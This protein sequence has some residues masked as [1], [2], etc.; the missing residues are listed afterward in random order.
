MNDLIKVVE[1]FRLSNRPHFDGDKFSATIKFSDDVKSLLRLLLDERFQAGR[2][3]DLEIDGCAIYEAKDIPDN[4]NIVAY[5]FKVTQRSANR[6]YKN[7]SELVKIHTLKKGVMPEF[8]YVIEDDY[9]SGEN[10]KPTYIKKLEDICNLIESLSKLAHFHDTKND[11]KVTFYRLVFILHS[12][13]KSTSV[14][15]ETKITE[16]VLNDNEINLNLINS[17]VQVESNADIH[18]VEKI[19]TFRNTIIE[20]VSRNGSSFD[21]LIENWNSICELYS[22]NLAAYMSAFSFRKARKEVVDAE[23]EYSE[24]FSKII[25]EISNKALAIPISLA[26]SIAI[27]NLTSK[28]DWIVTFLGI[29]ITAIISSAMIVSQKKQLDRITHSK[30]IL[31]TQIKTRIKD[32]TS[33]LKASFQETIHK[34]DDNEDFCRKVLDIL[35]SLA[36][37]PTFI[38]IIGIFIKLMPNIN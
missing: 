27:F 26:G 15:I 18:Y 14:V 20:Y 2:L 10:N 31:F 21:N 38:G 34:L 5:T 9:C 36:W 30:E 23:L 29:I 17:L 16:K 37:M 12:E 7:K 35:L 8:F 32:D 4:A 13:S 6:F 24:K 11:N 3:D 1:L 22:N 28:S 19:N 33:D 25:S